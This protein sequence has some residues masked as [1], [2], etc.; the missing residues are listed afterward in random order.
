MVRKLFCIAVLCLT[1]SSLFSQ[2]VRS[3][4]NIGITVITVLEEAGN[5]DLWVGS[6]SQGVAFYNDSARVWSYYNTSTVP[7]FKSDSITSIAFGLVGGVKHAFIGTTNGLVYSHANLWDTLPLVSNAQSDRYVTGVSLIA[8]DTLWATTQNGAIAY[9]TTTLH[10]AKAY[11]SGNSTLPYNVTSVSQRGGVSC[12]GFTLGTPDNGAVYT[13]DGS[14]FTKIDTSAP[15]FKLV[16]NRVQAIWI[17]NNCNRR[18]IGTKAG[19]SECPTGIPCQNFTIANGLPENDVTSI[20]MACNGNI[21]VGMRDSGIV[22]F[23]GTN[24]I[25]G[26]LTTANGLTSNQVRS[27]AL[28]GG[29][30]NGYVGTVDGNIAVTDTTNHVTNVLNGVTD[31]SANAPDVHVYPQPSGTQLS[32]RMGKEY[33]DAEIYITDVSGRQMKHI[34][35]RNA[36]LITTDVSALPEGLYFYRL[37][38]DGQ[39]L[40]TGKVEVMR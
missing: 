14:S 31:I 37:T 35:V 32:F 8:S 11:T 25:I 10:I 20:A 24:T 15:N 29:N 28:T 3:L 5:G 1:V 16:D 36:S 21:W 17:D 12:T 19:F 33:T 4:E 9:D 13:T 22:I 38:N 2:T 39:Q 6:A 7:Q 18:L 34:P 40:K 30:C 23:N 26:R 27:I